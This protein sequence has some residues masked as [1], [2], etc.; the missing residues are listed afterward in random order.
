MLEVCDPDADLDVLKKLIKM[1]TGHTIKL[2]KEQTCQV[3]DDIKAG[4]LPLP[5]L[6]M[7]SNK[8]YLVDKKSPLKL[9]DYEILFDSSSKR[10]DIKK[11]ARKVGLLKVDQM[12]KSQMIDSIGKRL[13][14]MKIHEPVKIGKVVVKK[15]PEVFN[16]T[17]VANNFANTTLVNNRKNTTLVN[18]TLVKNNFANTTLV[19]NTLVN[20][21]AVANNTL[22]NNRKNTTLVKNSFANTNVVKRPTPT[23]RVTFP[24]GGLFVKGQR[25]KFLNGRVSAVK[26]PVP[27][28]IKLPDIKREVTIKEN[29]ERKKRSLSNKILEAKRYDVVFDFNTTMSNIDSDEKFNEMNRK[30]DVAIEKVV[31]KGRN[32]L[33]NKIINAGVKNTFMNKVTAIKSLK[34]LKNIRR[35][36]ENAITTK[37]QNKDRQITKYMEKLGLNKQDIKSILN[38]NLTLNESRSMADDLL[39][40]KRRLELTKLLDNKKVPIADRKQFYN[41]IG[42]NSNIERNIDDYLYEKSRENIYNITQV[43]DKYNLKNENRQAIL[44]D[45]NYYPNMTVINVKNQASKRSTEFKREK[46]IALRRYLK[47]DL[48]LTNDDIETIMKNFNLNPR[49]MNALREKAKKLKTISGEKKR[50]TERIR[51]AREKNNLNL[52]INVNIK[53]KNN[54]NNLNKKI[55]KAYINES[56]KNLSKRALNH[57]IDISKELNSIESMNNVRKLKN[58]LDRL[59]MDKKNTNLKKI[60]KA[61]AN[62]NQ[63]NKNRFLKRFT[64]QNNSTEN[65]LKNIQEF[66]NAK[67]KRD[68]HLAKRNELQKF[69]NGL[70]NLTINQKTI[71]MAR[72][73]NHTTPINDIKRE[74]KKIDDAKKKGKVVALERAKPKEENNFNA[75]KAM[76]NLNRNREVKNLKNYVMKSSLPNNKKQAYIKQIEKPGTNLKPIPKLVNQNVRMNKLQTQL[77]T[78]ILKVV[79]GFTGQY[80]RAWERAV[81]EAKTMPRLREIGTDL[82]KKSLLRGEIEKSDIGPLVKRGHLSRV[83][84]IK[85]DVAKRRRIFENQKIQFKTNPL[86]NNNVKNNKLVKP[87]KNLMNGFKVYNVPTNE[88]KNMKTAPGIKKVKVPTETEKMKAMVKENMKFNKK[89]NEKRRLLREKSKPKWKNEYNKRL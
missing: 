18:N 38:R 48:K 65:I 27:P 64:N 44:N 43:L 80:R 17:A 10:A 15:K 81:E 9:T 45:W 6:I 87:R 3:Y 34:N 11:V 76:E 77:R 72:V 21:T 61:I 20:N 88:L 24:K 1:N 85:D 35:Q 79:T 83:M 37:K 50:I 30:V 70:T 56:R 40:K 51:K 42:T 39:D 89:L 46:E 33:S 75:Q 14:Y 47:D 54:V 78:D 67:M 26:K 32:T 58:K 25:P 22:V 60:E 5:P 84:N 7:S 36:I 59:I 82:T 2:T 41:K 4:K 19:N 49:N 29:L 16:N 62:L 68:T 55:N 23:T 57:N 52:K 8:T 63:E 13:K 53:N 12:T 71:F 31:N 28:K 86:Y 73:K 69:L 74:A 66:K